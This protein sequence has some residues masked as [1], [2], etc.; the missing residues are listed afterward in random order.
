[1]PRCFLNRKS[2]AALTFL[3]HYSLRAASEPR[4][5]VKKIPRLREMRDAKLKTS[6]RDEVTSMRDEVISCICKLH[7]TFKV[8]HL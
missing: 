4:A 5:E 2:I 8:S 3:E 1:M 6:M 7:S